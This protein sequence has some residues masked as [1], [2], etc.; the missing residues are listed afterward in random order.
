MDVAKINMQKIMA[1]LA[2][3]GEKPEPLTGITETL[4]NIPYIRRDGSMD[5]R[6]VRLFA[7]DSAERPMPL[8][9]V[10]HYEMPA[11]SLEIRDYLLKGWAV[12]SAAEFKNDYNSVL[13]SD[14]L[15]FNNAALYT[16]RNRSEID[17]NR[18]AVVGGSAGGYMSLMLNAMQLGICCS[19][20]NGPVCNVHFNFYKY[21]TDAN[22]FNLEAL[23]ALPKEDLK[24]P[25]K[26]LA[27]CPIPFVGAISAGAGFDK[28]C[29]WFVDKTDM[30]NW[31]CISPTALTECF[32]NPLYITQATSDILVPIEQLTREYTY[33][34]G[35]T[36]P[37][38]YD[39][40]LGDCPGK[41]GK[42]LCERL[43]PEELNLFQVPV[44]TDGSVTPMAFDPEKRFQVCITDEGAPQSYA[45]HNLGIAKGRASDV[46]YIQHHFDRTAAQTN[47]LTTGKLHLL[48]QR[49]AGQAPQ[50]VSH[51]GVDDAVYGSLAV[52]RKEIL[53]QLSKWTEDNGVA[54]FREAIQ[55]AVEADAVWMPALREIEQQISAE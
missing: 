50:L 46:E 1:M 2:Q 21:F 32:C 54:A 16:L 55:I 45:S 24:N 15:I 51:E 40:R 53:D 37:E 44:I 42:A 47:V 18:I 39:A 30:A 35:E 11:D 9:Y 5:E 23:T 38:G 31:E 19:V 10:A 26:L 43:E 34:P 27:A 41:L 6:P 29:D 17:K 28:C 4:L 36:L 49:Y 8:V 20:A 33:A 7:P 14:A 13:T 3:T 22:R 48:A 12:A 52:Y 25:M